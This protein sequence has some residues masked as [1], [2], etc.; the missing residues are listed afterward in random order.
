MTKD[1]Y[2]WAFS[3]QALDDFGEMEFTSLLD[4]LSIS[5]VLGRL[6]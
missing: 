1:K 3:V 5:T 2:A 4:K 6:P